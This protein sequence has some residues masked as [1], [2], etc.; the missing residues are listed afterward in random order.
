MFSLVT[1]STRRNEEFMT[2]LTA[3]RLHMTSNTIAPKYRLPISLR[4]LL[5]L[6]TFLWCCWLNNVYLI[7]EHSRSRAGQQSRGFQ[8]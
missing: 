2:E 1:D 5:V 7:C 4:R 3:R 8:H 6:R